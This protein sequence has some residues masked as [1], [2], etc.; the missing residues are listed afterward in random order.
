[1]IRRWLFPPFSLALSRT[2]RARASG[3]ILILAATLFCTGQNNLDDNLTLVL[4]MENEARYASGQSTRFTTADV[5]T[6]AGPTRFD[7]Y[8]TKPGI[9]NSTW[10]DPILDDELAALIQNATISV[11][12]AIFDFSRQVIIDAILE[13]RQ[14]GVAVRMVGDGDN[15]HHTGYSQLA[16]A[17]IPIV[18]RP[19]GSAIMHHKF[20]I[21]DSK[22]VWTGSANLSDNDIIRNNNNALILEHPGLAGQLKLEFDEMFAGRFGGAKNPVVN[23]YTATIN[24]VLTEVYTG[25]A[26]NLMAEL[27]GRV[28]SA[29]ESIHFLIFTFTRS[30]L[31]DRLIARRNA[32][33]AVT[34]VFEQLQAGGAYSQDTALAASGVPVYIDG[35]YNSIGQG[36]GMVHHKVMIIDGNSTSDPMVITGSF[37]WTDAAQTTNDEALF[38]F[39]SRELAAAYL[40]EYCYVVSTAT[41]HGSYQ[42]SHET[43]CG[44]KL[45]I[46]ETL[47]NPE[48]DDTGKE[49]IEITNSGIGRVDLTGWT[50]A[51]G[52]VIRH[53]FENWFSI[54][55]DGVTV[56]FDSGTH[57]EPGAIL[58]STG[59][60]TLPNT[61]GTITLKNHVGTTVDTFTYSTASSG[62][63]FNRSP[64][65]TPAATVARHNQIPG[66]VGSVSP[67]RKLDQS[68]YGGIATVVGPDLPLPAPGEL[69]ITQIASRGS[70]ASDEYIEIYN[71]TGKLL[72]VG[73]I[74]LQYQAATCGSFST[75]FTLPFGTIL[76]P[77]QFFLIGNSGYVTQN[78]MVADGTFVSGIADAGLVRLTDANNTILDLVSYGSTACGG[79]GGTSAP[80]PTAAN[81]IHRKGFPYTNAFPAQDTDSN[82]QDFTA[83]ARNPRSSVADFQPSEGIQRPAPGE[84]LI[85]QLAT[86]GSSS[87]YDEFIEIYN[88]TRK[89]L[90]LDAVKMEYQTSSCT[91]WSGRATLSNGTLLAPGQFYLA[92]SLRGYVPLVSGPA[93]DLELSQ[94]GIADS[95]LVRLVGSTGNTLDAVGFGN[96][97]ACLAEGSAAPLHVAAG[98]LWRR[99][100]GSYSSQAVQDSQDNASDFLSRSVRNPRNSQVVEPA[101]Q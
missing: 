19:A 95:A 65:G 25:P 85:S 54:P 30:D 15:T 68:A 18:N 73:G 11:D 45:A 20:A 32:G 43:G 8:F 7:A 1:M 100:D 62:I 88:P 16:G 46:N 87:A 59:N 6:I 21:V 61:G 82:G 52:G 44:G 55:A 92:A 49:Y 29:S 33:V 35:N 34:G 23:G 93:P 12:L 76:S 39:H 5:Y 90:T 24:G 80:A 2:K 72:S 3:G 17:G 47:P 28:D 31:K 27:L 42:G 9:S 83:A 63:S 94:S 51:V 64:D 36:G 22:F 14:R 56:V 74:R 10:I 57:T 71:R 97:L 98:S 96:S 13:A 48:G 77:G 60:L 4:A 67:G 101:P 89:N 41:L 86:R 91:G 78:G 50:I 81:S 66:A 26:G 69:V 38:I 70:T 58:S 79:E 99:P 84:L 37:N 75:R 40:E 53:A